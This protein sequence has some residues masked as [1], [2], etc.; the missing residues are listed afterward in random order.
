MRGTKTPYFTSFAKKWWSWE[1]SRAISQHCRTKCLTSRASTIPLRVRKIEAI[2]SA[3]LNFS[4]ACKLSTHLL[5]NLMSSVNWTGLKKS[6]RFNCSRNFLRPV[7][8]MTINR[9][10]WSNAPM[11]C[12]NARPET[13]LNS[14]RST[15][16][17]TNCVR[18][19]K[20]IYDKPIRSR[21]L[22]SVVSKRTIQMRHRDTQ[23]RVCRLKSKRLRIGSSTSE[24]WRI[25]EMRTFSVLK[26]QSKPFKMKY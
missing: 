4:K 10:S 5:L 6:T 2:R 8:I 11:N 23:C 24:R 20:P 9:L 14:V 25:R 12:S 13:L 21:S 3:V 15:W 19:N 17:V 26:T 1:Q 7:R 22:E 18:V 16:F